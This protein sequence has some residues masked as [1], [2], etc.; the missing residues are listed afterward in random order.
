MHRIRREILK[1]KLEEIIKKKTSL[2]EISKQRENSFP[3]ARK[4]HLSTTD[5]SKEWFAGFIA[6]REEIGKFFEG[7]KWI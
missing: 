1:E 2:Q 6:A 4:F 5:L 7:T 3:S